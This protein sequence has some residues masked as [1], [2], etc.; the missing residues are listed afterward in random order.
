MTTSKTMVPKRKKNSEVRGTLVESQSMLNSPRPS[1]YDSSRLPRKDSASQ[2]CY[3]MKKEQL[4]AP[5]MSEYRKRYVL[6]YIVTSTS[7]F[8]K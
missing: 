5:R 7:M 6:I 4:N 1:K 2:L 8:T 3:M